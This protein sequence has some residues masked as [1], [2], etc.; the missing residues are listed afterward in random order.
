VCC[1]LLGNRARV[2]DR[3]N[4]GPLL[5]FFFFFYY[6]FGLREIS[7]FCGF[8]LSSVKLALFS[9]TCVSMV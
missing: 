3:K 2:A 5:F 9:G 7:K 8:D 4:G 6:Y 1:F